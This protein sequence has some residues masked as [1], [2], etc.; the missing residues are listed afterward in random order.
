MRSLDEIL[1]CSCGGD[2]ECHDDG[3]YEI[4][5]CNKC[6]GIKRIEKLSDKRV[7]EVAKSL[8]AEGNEFATSLADDMVALWAHIKKL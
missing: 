2:L 3:D 5:K 4:Y 8:Y 1:R 6:D 7:A